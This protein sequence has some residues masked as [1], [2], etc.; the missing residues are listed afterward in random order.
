MARFQVKLNKVYI[1]GNPIE[2]T[3]TVKNKTR[4]PYYLLKQSLGMDE[5]DHDCF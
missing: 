5:L 4:F 1:L 3:I 2:V